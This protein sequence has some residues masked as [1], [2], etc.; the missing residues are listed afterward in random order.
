MNIAASAATVSIN[1]IAQ[2]VGVYLQPE[3]AAKTGVDKNFVLNTIVLANADS[4]TSYTVTAGKTLYITQVA[5]LGWAELYALSELQQHCAVWLQN[6]TSGVLSIQV[7]GN[8]GGWFSFGK[9]I[10][11]TTGQIM[12]LYAS[13]H[14]NHSLNMTVQ[15]W[16]YEI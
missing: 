10:K 8:G 16:G 15:A 9:P 13:N 4:Y 12:R 6:Q 3:Y 5:A 7:G 1:I 2:N 11:F 14:A